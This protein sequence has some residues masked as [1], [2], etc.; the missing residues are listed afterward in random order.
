MTLD[1]TTDHHSKLDYRGKRLQIP[2]QQ[3]H[4]II[5]A[6]LSAIGCD[7][8]TAEEVASHLTETSLHGIESHGVMRILQYA[9][10]FQSGYMTPSATAELLRTDAGIWQVS[11]HGG[12]GIPVMRMA[13]DQVM[14]LAGETGIAAVSIHDVGHTGR[15]GAFADRAAEAGFLT[16]TIGGGNRAT[17]R[18]VAPHGGAR[19]MLPTNPW[20]IG[21]PGGNDGP[22][23]IDFATSKIAGGWIYAARS[24]GASLPEGCLIDRDGNPTTDPEDYFDGGAILPA[25]E[26]KG[27]ALALMAELIGEALL[28]AVATEANWLVIAIDTRKYQPADRMTTLAEEILADI[29]S[30]PPR[31]GFSKVEIPGE[32]ERQHHVDAGG[33]IPLPEETWQ[34]IKALAHSLGCG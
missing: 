28:G 11:G 32:R 34:Q 13:F 21:I 33:M 27:Y 14:T 2:Q 5:R 20:C 15:H 7:A 3:A 30:C 29:R 24:A 22:V 1:T 6:I 4:D 18:Q 9:S 26:H 16:I 10:Q 17:W 8:M 19:P 31:P 12:I 23:V 25:G